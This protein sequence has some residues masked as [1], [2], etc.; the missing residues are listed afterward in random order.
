[1][2]YRALPVGVAITT[3][4]LLSAAC[5]DGIVAPPVN[6]PPDESAGPP[7]QAHFP[8][9]PAGAL[10]Y[11]RIT[12]SYIPGHSRYVFYDDGTFGLQYWRPDW[13]FFEY[14]G[15]H[16][17]ADSAIALYFDDANTAGAWLASGILSADTL[18]VKYNLIM[19]LADFED[20]AYVLA[21]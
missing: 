18:I 5:Q 7:V 8:P 6:P 11:D 16:V 14:T 3:L 12:S 20:G 15:R 21:R 9:V 10:A 4:L 1:M 19:M 13:G 2:S 17:R